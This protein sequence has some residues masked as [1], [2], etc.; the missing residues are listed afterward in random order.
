MCDSLYVKANGELPCWDDVGEELIFRKLD[1][2]KLRDGLE[3]NIFHSP[4][5][6]HIPESFLRGENPRSG[7][8]ERC[9]VR[10]HGGT[11]L[12][13]RPK[14]MQVLHLEASYLCHLSCPQ[15]IPSSLRRDLKD[16]PYHLT[17]PTLQAL[18]NQL[19]S[20]GIE[21]IRLVHFEGRGDA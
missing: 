15:C 2:E 7:L 12:R 10:G 8:C 21:S 3:R 9:A 17:V 19:R 18:L 14:V 13:L 16:A 1:A 20:E 5:L 6:L 11:D 4:E